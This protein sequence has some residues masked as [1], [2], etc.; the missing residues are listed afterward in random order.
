MVA[1]EFILFWV[2]IAFGFIVAASYI[3]TKLAL[4]SYFDDEEF[5]PTDVFRVEDDDGGR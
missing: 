2:P 4:R 3:G 1:I 5:S